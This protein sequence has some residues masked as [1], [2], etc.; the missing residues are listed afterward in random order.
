MP[1][2]GPLNCSQAELAA[3]VDRI[4]G[5]L[6]DAAEAQPDTP[7]QLQESSVVP[8]GDIVHLAVLTE[9]PNEAVR[10]EIAAPLESHPAMDPETV[11][12]RMHGGA[13]PS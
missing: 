6:R 3:W 8:N 4:D 5:G 10:T 11:R 12:R 9:M 7:T 2:F 13:L 1:G